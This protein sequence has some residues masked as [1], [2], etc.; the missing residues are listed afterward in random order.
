[1]NVIRFTANLFTGTGFQLVPERGTEVRLISLNGTVAGPSLG[2]TIA[3]SYRLNNETLLA[4][5]SNGCIQNT[6][7]LFAAI[8]AQANVP[9]PE[10]T[11]P[12]TG[13]VTYGAL[14]T[15]RTIGLPDIWWSESVTV[16][17]S[18]GGAVVTAV[19][20]VYEIQRLRSFAG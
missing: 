18:A 20:G 17:A 2:E 16:V 12:I 9:T 8:G 1:V 15:S 6:V 5:V 3:V 4:V 11:D 7:Q 13:D 19:T 10:N 14:D